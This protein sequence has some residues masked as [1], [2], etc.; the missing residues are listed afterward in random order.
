LERRIILNLESI[1]Y[2][3]KIKLMNVCYI[4]AITD[5]YGKV[6]YYYDEY[7]P[8]DVM[9]FEIDNM[10]VSEVFE[11]FTSQHKN[12]L[13]L[14]I[15]D[16]HDYGGYD[17]ESGY[18]EGEPVFTIQQEILLQDN[19]KEFLKQRYRNIIE[20]NHC[21]KNDPQEIKEILEFYYEE[22]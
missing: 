11:D 14:L 12:S 3:N 20:N 7:S 4:R 22:E 10:G 8:N 16:F 1:I 19:Y 9:Y 18:W 21:S 15:T 13:V 6:I 2:E 5:N 17:Y